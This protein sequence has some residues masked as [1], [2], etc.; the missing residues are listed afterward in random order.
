V[1]SS[2]DIAWVFFSGKKSRDGKRLSPYC[3][4]ETSLIFPV[5]LWLPL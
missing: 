5:Q 2:E 1:I 3:Q 4:E